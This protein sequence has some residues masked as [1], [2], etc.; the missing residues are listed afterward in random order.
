MAEHVVQWSLSIVR[1]AR[2]P[3]AVN[4][5][6]TREVGRVGVRVEELRWRTYE[7]LV[8]GRW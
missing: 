1:T 7:F 6:P 2:V 4:P 3:V 5:I 8:C